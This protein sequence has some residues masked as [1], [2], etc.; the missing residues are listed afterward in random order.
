MNSY[1]I[2]T[3]YICECIY[4]EDNMKT[5]KIDK[6]E[7]QLCHRCYLNYKSKSG[8]SSSSVEKLR[9]PHCHKSIKMQVI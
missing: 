8:S 1:I 5:I 7:F 6:E 3:C 4:N 9:C 2:S